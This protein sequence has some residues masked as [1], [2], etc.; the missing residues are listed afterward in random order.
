MCPCHAPSA[1]ASQGHIEQE[2]V[3]PQN[4]VLQAQTGSTSN[5]GSCGADDKDKPNP[6]PDGGEDKAEKDVEEKDVKQLY[7]DEAQL[8][9][10]PEADD[11][12]LFVHG[13]TLRRYQKQALAWMIAREKR[14]YVTEE[15]C[16]GLVLGGGAGTLSASQQQ[17][18]PMEDA[19]VCGDKHA[20]VVRDG[21]VRVVAW[22]HLQPGDDHGG[23]PGVALHPLWERRAAASLVRD[24]ACKARGVPDEGGGTGGDDGRRNLSHPEAFYVNVYSRQFRREFPPA[25][26]GCRGGILADE[27]GM[28][29][30]R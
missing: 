27:M 22:E 10:M 20:V 4:P 21:C 28:G 2:Q 18:H 9:G 5:G 19:S 17:R 13:L 8:C 15:D 12:K 6:S 11:P 1:Y 24:T 26:L 14:R 16:T 29:K 7:D 30:V 25:S 23:G 3:K